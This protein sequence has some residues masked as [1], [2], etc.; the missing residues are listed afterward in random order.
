MHRVGLFLA[1]GLHIKDTEMCKIR[2]PKRWGIP[3]CI[4]EAYVA[5][6]QVIPTL[7]VFTQTTD[8]L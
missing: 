2:Q 3:R 8:V 5:I 1:E 7:S 4:D 6:E